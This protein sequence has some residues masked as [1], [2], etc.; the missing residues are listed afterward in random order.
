M[1]VFD[2]TILYM[3]IPYTF[4][5]IVYKTIF[6]PLEI[7]L[8]TYIIKYLNVTVLGNFYVIEVPRVAKTL[9]IIVMYS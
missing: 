4:D 7:L 8:Y 6:T 9:I 1:E 5:E 2:D 3:P